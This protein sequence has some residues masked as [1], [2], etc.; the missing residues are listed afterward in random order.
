MIF[1]Y[2]QASVCNYF[3]NYGLHK[4]YKLS[5]NNLFQKRIDLKKRFFKSQL[6][7]KVLAHIN[8]FTRT[9]FSKTTKL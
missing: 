2:C 5:R 7:L 4:N 9:A 6:I 3:D 8:A 1:T